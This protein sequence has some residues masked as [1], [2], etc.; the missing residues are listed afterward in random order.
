MLFILST[1]FLSLLDNSAYGQ[2]TSNRGSEFWIAFPTHVPDIEPNS[3]ARLYAKMSV[4]I[5]GG[6][7]SS[8]KVT[9]GTFSLA[10]TTTANQVTEIDIPRDQAYID[11]SEDYE[12]LSN[13]AIHVQV[14]P[15]KPKIVVYAHIYAGNRSAASLILPTEALSQEYFSMNYKEV[16]SEGLNS[17]V[18]VATEPN[19][20]FTVRKGPLIAAY[21]IVLPNPGDVYEIQSPND[22]TGY[23]IQSDGPPGICSRFAVFSGSSGVV[24]NNPPFTTDSFDPLFQQLYP[25]ESWGTKYGYIP[26]SKESPYQAEP[27]RRAG[28]FVRIIARDD[29]TKVT[30]D[31]TLVATLNTGEFYTTPSPLKEPASIEASKP[32][33]VA[34]YALS[35][36]VANYPDLPN[37][38]TYSDPDMVLLNPISFNI[39]DITIFSSGKEHILEQYVNIL[40]ATADAPTFRINGIAPVK[41]FKP[42]STMPGFSYIQISLPQTAGNT[43]HLTA[44]GGFNAIAYGFGDV[45]SY[46]YSAGTNLATTEKITGI[47]SADGAEIDQACTDGN[48]FFQLTLPYKSPKISWKMDDTE[49]PVVQLNP[50]T[51]KTTV[52]GRDSYTYKFPKTPSYNIVKDHHISIIASYDVLTGACSTGEQEI[53]YDFKTVMPPVVDFSSLLSDCQNTYQFADASNTSGAAVAKYDWD[54]GDPSS[55]PANNASTIQNPSHTFGATGTYHVNLKITLATGCQSFQVKDVIINN[56]TPSFTFSAPV[57]TGKDVL[58]EENSNLQN[59]DAKSWIWEFGDGQIITLANIRK[60]SHNY[61]TAGT[62]TVRLKLISQTGCLSAIAEKTIVV[63]ASPA[64]DFSFP[65]V[66]VQDNFTAFTTTVS[67]GNIITYQW[68]F[69]DSYANPANANTSSEKDPHH[70]YTHAG[71]YPVTLIATSASGC[72]VTLQKNI[73]VNGEPAAGLEITT[74]APYCSGNTIIFKNTSA[75]P[76]PGIITKL[77]IYFDASANLSDKSIINAPSPGQLIPHVFNLPAGTLSKDYTIRIVAYS[78]ETCFDQ[79]DQAITVFGKSDIEFNA[80]PPV[81]SSD[82]PFQLSAAEK[83]AIPG[84]GIYS[85]KGVSPKGEFSPSEAGPGEHIITYTFTPINGCPARAEQNITVFQQPDVQDADFKTANGIPI[86]LTPAYSG[87]IKTYQWQPSEGLDHDNIA[88]PVSHA[89]RNIDYLVTVSNGVCSDIATVHLTVSTIPL[90]ANTFTPN[91]DGKNDRWDLGDMSAYPVF[92]LQVF[93]RYGVILFQTSD[94]LNRWDGNY[95][96]QQVPAGTYY[97]TIELGRGQKSLSGFLTLIR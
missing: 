9:V 26:F 48:F 54:F 5:T 43:F 49:A 34:Q 77:E 58:F 3:G 66:C 65:A 2:A 52:N 82:K 44:V 59:F 31:G 86:K 16:N 13:R 67:S 56:F 8:G 40:I 80:V 4:F 17:I 33:S 83:N 63:N 41:P 19:T 23:S 24:I 27:V 88:N 38:G 22:L 14:D 6:E 21:Q 42:M 89:T 97:Y 68:N 95:K 91:G 15:G 29:G 20:V 78:G 72:M 53:S 62:Y 74:M 55:G 93:N 1:G 51:V 75:A 18:V 69:G 61:L 79:I 73:L 71:N 96:G 11:Y 37:A 64:V 60:V 57:C 47:N 81:C 35:Q 45:E 50:A 84:N 12:V 28:Q 87:S 85:G 32:I 10:F 30:I 7:A 46:A 94:P 25:I 39:K 76:A 36:D 92:K 70:R 90:I